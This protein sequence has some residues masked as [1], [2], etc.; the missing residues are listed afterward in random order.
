MNYPNS[1]YLLFSSLS[2]SL[3]MCLKEY[4]FIQQVRNYH[5]IEL[6]YLSVSKIDPCSK[7]HGAVLCLITQLCPT[8]CDPVDCSPRGSSVHEDSPGKNT[9]VVCH[10]LLQGIFPTQGLK[11]GHL[12]C[13]WILYHLRYQGSPQVMA[14]MV[15]PGR[16]GKI[17]A[18][19]KFCIEIFP[20]PFLHVLSTSWQS[21]IIQACPK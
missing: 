21:N 20:S 18:A 15:L 11:P 4:C 12:H 17:A 1:H 13:K 8:L 7:G 2:L 6:P 10:A 3:C 9:G 16:P 14:K 5:F 19:D